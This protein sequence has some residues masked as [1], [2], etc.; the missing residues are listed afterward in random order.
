MRNV[1]T[2]RFLFLSGSDITWDR[3]LETRS[4]AKNIVGSD[5]NYYYR[6]D[7]L[8]RNQGEGKYVFENRFTKRY[9]FSD[10]DRECEG[11]V[12]GASL[13]RGSDDNYDNRALW[14]IVQQESGKYLVVSVVN[15]RYVSS[16]GEPPTENERGWDN[17]P[18]CVMTNS[19]YE[20]RALSEIS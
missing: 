2:R 3:G 16:L 10:G 19:N 14:Y 5:S 17:A 11:S 18:K 20:D 12:N 4:G 7:W 9:L 8:I 13:C 15:S 1:R 6:A